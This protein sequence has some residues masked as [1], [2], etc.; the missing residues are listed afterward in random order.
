MG[1]IV[2]SRSVAAIGTSVQKPKRPAFAT[3]V[4][5][6][7]AAPGR[8]LV[9]RVI[10]TTAE[11]FGTTSDELV[12]AR[13]TRSLT[14]HRQVAMYVAREITGRSLFFI[15]R[16]IG[17]RHHTTILHGVRTIRGLLVAGDVETMAAVAAIMERLQ[18]KG[19]AQGRVEEVRRLA[20]RRAVSHLGGR[21]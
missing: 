17:E 2:R 9:R 21:R 12:S 6:L 14:R 16:K 15:G 7:S 3:R 5:Q 13:L 1:V 4:G 20:N 19:G 18:V 11:H 10:T 8:I